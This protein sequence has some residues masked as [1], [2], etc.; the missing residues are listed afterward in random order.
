MDDIINCMTLIRK[1]KCQKC[2]NYH[3]FHHTHTQINNC[4][5]TDI[6]ELLVAG[7]RL[8]FDK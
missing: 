1:N 7:G 4:I 2:F 5:V 3:I 6:Y 8:R